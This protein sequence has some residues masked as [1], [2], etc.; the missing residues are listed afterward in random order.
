MARRRGTT[1]TGSP[2]PDTGRGSSIY[3]RWLAAVADDAGLLWDKLTGQN[4][5]PD[6]INHSGGGT[7]RGAPICMPLACQSIN[8]S[9]GLIGSTKSPTLTYILAVPV[10]V[11]DDG[12]QT[13]RL[14]VNVSFSA[15][16]PVFVEVRDSTWS[17]FFGPTPAVAIAPYASWNLTLSPGVQY[18]LVSTTTAVDARYILDWSL[19][20]VITHGDGA[21]VTAISGASIGDA[22]PVGSIAPA[23]WID[24]YDEQVQADG[25]LDAFVLT[26]LNRNINGML[27]YVMGGSVPGNLNYSTSPSR[28]NNR[29]TFT[30]EAVIETP[31]ACIAFGG[32]ESTGAPAIDVATGDGL[33]DW[34]APF[35]AAATTPTGAYVGGEASTMSP[36][37][38]AGTLRARVLA[39]STAGTPTMVSATVN[40]SAA[41][42]FVRLG[43]SNFYEA[44]ITSVPFSAGASTMR[45]NQVRITKATPVVL[46][47]IS[48][49]GLCV[50][51]G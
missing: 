9:I 1:F 28:R 50:Y 23:S 39:S 48:I 16:N 51:V 14:E 4:G 32:V 15:A 31:C 37:A 29:S 27:E 34:F 3:Q 12:N 8:R 19:T 25:P 33:A 22:I 41:F 30:N 13:Y 42:N 18:V 40:G 26:R 10:F 36:Y 5:E 43:S 24:I 49:L 45:P 11:P 2:P 35:P 46:G 21:G 47:E 20:P 7:L 17:A 44:F 38:V 6:P